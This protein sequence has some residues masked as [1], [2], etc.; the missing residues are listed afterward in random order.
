[1]IDTQ[2]LQTQIN[3][4]R[5]KQAAQDTAVA[6]I[7]AKI[8]GMGKKVDSLDATVSRVGWTV[9]LAVVAAVLKLVIF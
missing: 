3:A 5:E 7:H 8:D 6:V 1:M 2:A 9:I 4:L